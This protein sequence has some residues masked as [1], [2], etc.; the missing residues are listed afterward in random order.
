MFTFKKRWCKPTKCH[1][2][3]FLVACFSTWRSPVRIQ[4]W[5]PVR[6]QLWTPVRIWSLSGYSSGPL[7]EYSSEPLSGYRSE[8]LSG[9]I[10]CRDTALNPCPDT[11]PVQIQLWRFSD[12]IPALAWLSLCHNTAPVQHLWHR[13]RNPE[14]ISIKREVFSMQKTKQNY[15]ISHICNFISNWQIRF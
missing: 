8:F 7:S 1:S 2:F 14:L 9:Y 12:R 4:L 15:I 5:T 11:T 3:H 6:I 13:M 10:P